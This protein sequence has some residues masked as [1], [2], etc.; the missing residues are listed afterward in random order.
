MK[1]TLMRFSVSM[2]K[3]LLD[4][5]D[6]LIS[7]RGYTNRS[8]AIR[9]FIRK[10]I[11]EENIHD[12]KTTAFGVLSYVY[13]HHVRE[14][15]AK[16]TDFQHHHFK[17]IISTSHIHVDHDNCLES[18]ILRDK[19]SKITEISSRILSLKGVK[20]GKLALTLSGKKM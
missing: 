16:L 8:E 17:S 13:D 11:V 18:I 19:A 5:L 20:H 14:L 15:E 10:E 4:K 6:E 1:K 3:D 2:E 7:K 9:D 12:G